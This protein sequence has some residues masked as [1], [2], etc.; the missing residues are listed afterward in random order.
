MMKKTLAHLTFESYSAC[1][2]NCIYC[3]N[4]WKREGSKKNFVY[5]HKQA[6]KTLKQIY[7]QTEI[8]QVTITGGEPLLNEYVSE[9]ILIAKLNNSKVSIISNGN[10][11]ADFDYNL[12]KELNVGLIMCPL[13]SKTPALH[14]IMTSVNGSWAKSY[15]SILN[16][17]KIGIYVVP[18]IVLTK[19][20]FEEIGETLSFLN[21][22]GFKRISVNRYN[23][24]GEGIN[25][26]NIS[27]THLELNQ[28]FKI[29]NQIAKDLNLKITSNV[30]TPFC[31]LEPLDYANIGFGA[32]GTNQYKRPITV[33]ILGNLRACNH[34]PIT[35]GNVFEKNIYEILE[36]D[37]I[38]SWNVAKPKYC[39]DCNK[40]DR[41]FGGCKAAAEQVGLTINDVDPL[42]NFMKM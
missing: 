21:S 42:V 4:H 5:N 41:C 13:H 34:S 22:M 26:T 40:F 36:S 24:G 9:L 23:I 6:I 18:V 10:A 27:L 15:N 38:K 14:D 20:N 37:Y 31:V 32:C 8:N 33:D 28:T 3:Y 30:C 29:I 12:Y 35:A 17:Q 2:L 16:I 7:K 1:N 11:I 25:H 39:A 19:I